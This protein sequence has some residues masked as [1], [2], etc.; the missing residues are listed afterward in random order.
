MCPDRV[1][2][3]TVSPH[4]IIVHRTLQLSPSGTISTERALRVCTHQQPSCWPTPSTSPPSWPCPELSSPLFSTGEF[5]N[6]LFTGFLFIYLIVAQRY[7]V[8]PPLT[9]HSARVARIPSNIRGL[10][11]LERKHVSYFRRDINVA[12]TVTHAEEGWGG[13]RGELELGCQIFRL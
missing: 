9:R 5:W 7:K 1:L 2:G 3:V 10:C 11:I 6:L 8:L 12:T 4:F 13:L